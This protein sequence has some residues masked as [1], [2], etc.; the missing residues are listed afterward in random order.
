MDKE[1]VKIAAIIFFGL[2]AMV[3][4]GKWLAWQLAG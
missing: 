1:Q 2:S 4:L 3:L